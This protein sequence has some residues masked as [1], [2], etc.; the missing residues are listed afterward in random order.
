[1]MFLYDVL[2]FRKPTQRPSFLFTAA[3]L[4]T[5]GFNFNTSLSSTS[6]SSFSFSTYLPSSSLASSLNWS[7]VSRS[8]P[9]SEAIPD[10]L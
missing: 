6:T 1:M 10:R 2:V 5:G 4:A 8:H 7:E 3:R 9:E